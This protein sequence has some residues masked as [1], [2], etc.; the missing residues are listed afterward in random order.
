MTLKKSNFLIL[1]FVTLSVAGT[2][3]T[4]FF[5]ERFS[6]HDSYRNDVYSYSAIGHRG[7]YE[8][9]EDLYELK[10]Y[11]N[12]SEFIR[13][14]LIFEPDVLGHGK[15]FRAIN[16]YCEFC[17]LVLPK[18]KGFPDKESA[19]IEKHSLKDV[20]E[21]Q[22]VVDMFPISFENIK[23]IR[24][25]KISPSI[26]P[27]ALNAP[28]IEY[29]IQLVQGV[30]QEHILY[31]DTEKGALVF[32]ESTGEEGSENEVFRLVITD[33]DIIANH[34][35]DEDANYDFIRILLENYFEEGHVI[36][37][38][39]T[40]HGYK[41]HPSLLR[42]LTTFPLSLFTIQLLL[43]LILI[44][45][46]GLISFGAPSTIGSSPAFGTKG[47]I[48]NTVNL[49]SPNH[50]VFLGKQYAIA[51]IQD[52]AESLNAPLQ[53]TQE[54]LWKWLDTHAKTK[55]ISFS[56]QETMEKFLEYELNIKWTP[57]EVLS[58]V[59][60]IDRWKLSMKNERK[61]KGSV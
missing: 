24:A 28:K 50:S 4:L 25:E 6:T 51:A 1:F 8:A 39:E 56:V 54:E 20:S 58:L 17:T 31:G 14:A 42:L 19:H 52:V 59:Q 30:D 7:F 27:L 53:I 23:V 22:K 48:D 18:R 49:F 11:E 36:S 29:P 3:F 33:P 35:I 43:I 10:I 37:I 47:L 45:W 9:F 26:N 5:G 13:N 60:N 12:D 57:Q 46:R 41:Q 16:I 55:G 15:E 2:V 21:V 38:D 40:T 44:T 32:F 61:T 34:G